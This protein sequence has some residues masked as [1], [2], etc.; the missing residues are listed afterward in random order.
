MHPISEVRYMRLRRWLAVPLAVPIAFAAF[1]VI[2]PAAHASVGVGVQ[3]TPVRLASALRAGGSYALPAV[4]VVDTGTQPEDIGVRVEPMPGGAGREVPASWVRDTGPGLRLS[5][6]QSARIPLQ[7]A[8]PGGARAGRYLG[9]I[10]VTG[11]AARSAGRA[12]LGVAAATALEFSVTPAAPGLWPFPPSWL[13]W[14]LGGLM[15]I[16]L[17]LAAAFRSGLRVQIERTPAAARAAAR[18]ATRAAA[19]W[20]GR[21]RAAVALIAA[22]GLAACATGSTSTQTGTPGK[23]QSIAISLKVVPTV[24]SVTVSPS[25]ASFGGCTGGNGSVNTASTSAALGFPNGRCWLGTPGS[26]GSFPIT[27][28]NT[29]VAAKIFVSGASAVPSDGG[30]QWGLCNLGPNPAAACTGTGKKLPGANQY[31]VQNFA[32]G[33]VNPAGLTGTM[34]C[35]AEFASGSCQAVQGDSQQEGIELTGPSSTAD[36]STKWTVTVTWTAFTLVPPS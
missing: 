27:I 32:G 35:D 11:S 10:V 24:V 17:L 25:S 18:S 34:T 23:G 31:L 9:A 5:P 6:H 3:A 21:P 22:A 28:T 7:L 16:G 4:Y 33:D 14:I 20:R 13:W 12:N 29:G 26:H 8:V 19:R 30:T 36:L 15:V 1:S 2:L